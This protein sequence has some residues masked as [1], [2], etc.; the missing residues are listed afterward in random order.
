MSDPT[1]ESAV[2]SVSL[3]E[4]AT[5]E[6]K[7]GAPLASRPGV[8]TSEFALSI[9]AIALSACFAVDIIPT[10]GIY[11]KLGMLAAIVLTSL[12]YTVSRTRVKT[13][14]SL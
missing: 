2:T 14:G 7:L 3:T 11:A 1:T 12:G 8:R 4:T 13:G 9:F 5:T 6:L 10:S